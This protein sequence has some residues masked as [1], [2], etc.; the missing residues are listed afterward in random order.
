MSPR[1]LQREFK[2]TTG[3]SAYSWIVRERVERARELLEQRQVPLTRV[4]QAVGAGSVESL[5]HHFRRLVGTT[6]AAYRLR[7]TQRGGN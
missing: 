2:A 7:F 6:P 4:A 5:R 1:T 3:E